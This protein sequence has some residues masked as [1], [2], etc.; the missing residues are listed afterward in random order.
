MTIPGLMQKQQ[1]NLIAVLEHAARHFGSNEVVSRLADGNIHRQTYEQTF[2]RT[3][4]LANALSSLGVKSGD[5]VATLGWNDHRHLEAWYGIAGLGAVCHT[6]NPR[7][8]PEQIKYIINH[9]EDKVLL[10][11]PMFVP[12]IQQMKDELG[13]VEKIILLAGSNEG[14]DE[15]FLVFDELIANAPETIIWKEFDENAASSLCYTS[16]TTGN[17]K[18]VLYSHR[19]NILQ[20]YATVMSDCFGLNA[21]CSI[22]MIVPMFH[23]NSW[24]IAYSAPMT[25]AKLVLPGRQLDGGSVLSLIKEEKV[26]ISAGVPTIWHGLLQHAKESGNTLSP[27][28]EVI[29]GGSAVPKSMIETFI[30]DFDVDVIHA[31]GMTETSPLGCVNRPI[32]AVTDLTGDDLINHKCKQGRSVFGIDMKTVNDAG[33]ELP[34]DG[35]TIGRLLVKGHWVAEAYFGQNDKIVDDEGWFD[36]GDIA[37]I[38]EHGYM[39]ITDRAKDLIKSGGEWISSVDL[40]NAACGIQGVAQA[41]AIGISHP[42]WEERPLLLVVREEGANITDDNVF[43]ALAA[44]LAKWQLPDEVLFVETLPLTAT[45]KLDK[46]VLR[47][48]YADHYT[49]S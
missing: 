38:D 1:M 28:K 19:S 11:D 6:V 35:K 21:L 42:K 43:S 4:R 3:K 49:S 20:A 22:L 29:V 25:G 27:L 37:H 26:D 8:F 7:L 33:V 36:T 5:R 24:G 40:E 12:L 10:V 2:Q 45:G 31:W 16:G 9:A 39:T 30:N 14:C 44:E 17:P 18:G 13:S 41:C 34:R 32:A 46:K 15:E 23:A 47:V 48:E